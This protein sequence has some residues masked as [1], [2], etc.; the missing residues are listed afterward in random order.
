MINILYSESD[1]KTLMVEDFFYQDRTIF[2][3]TLEKWSSRYPVF[4][5]PRRFGKSLFISTLQYY[6]GLEY[7]DEFQSL[8]G[9]L[10]IGQNPT[11]LANSYLILRFEFSGIDTVTHESTYRGFS[12]NVLVAVRSFLAM[13]SQ[14]FNNEDK[15]TILAQQSPETVVKMLLNIAKANKIPHKIYILIDEYDHFANELL[16]FD[17]ERFKQGVGE[18]G[19]VRKF[20]ESP[21]MQQF[22]NF[23]T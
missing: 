11:K 18:N 12:T 6:Y 16:S 9:K 17:L 5:R 10:Y 20:Y 7:K 8:F 19:F 14:F 21:S 23:A 2:I 22:T 4:L 13:Y 1:F 15:H 3:E